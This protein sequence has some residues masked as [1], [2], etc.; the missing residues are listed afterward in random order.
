[1]FSQM[2]S[3]EGLKD[4]NSIRKLEIHSSK[5]IGD[6]NEGHQE[7]KLGEKQNAGA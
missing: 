6:N 5:G 4:L 7:N 1:M 2:S 3:E